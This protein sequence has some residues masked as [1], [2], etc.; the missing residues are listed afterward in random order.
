MTHFTGSNT[1]PGDPKIGKVRF[2]ESSDLIN[3]RKLSDFDRNWVFECMDF[4]ELAVDGDNSNKKWLLYDAS[5]DYEIGDFDG[6]EFVT[7]KELGIGD[8]GNHFYAGQTFNNAPDG[9]TIIIGWMSTRDK[10]IFI[11]NDMP[12]N[13][14]MSFPSTMELRTTENG[15]KLFRNPIREIEKLYKN[16]Y[17]YNNKSLSYINRSLDR[18]NPKLI[19]LSLNFKPIDNDEFKINIRGQEII[20]KNQY[21]EFQKTKIPAKPRNGKISIRVLLDRASLEIFVNDGENVMT[22][23]SV[24]DKNNTD[25]SLSSKRNMKISLKLNELKSS[26]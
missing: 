2:F 9:R 25:V 26:W 14:Q 3:W 5:F 19:D 17:T 12:W 16:T 11:E 22:T 7:D 24:S 13:Q 8:H 15:I 6:T 20:Y 10:N 1:G 4:V 21:V 23:Y 18:I